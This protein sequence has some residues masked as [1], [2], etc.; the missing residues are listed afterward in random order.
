MLRNGLAAQVF[1]APA[2]QHFSGG[3]R[4]TFETEC[5][6]DGFASDGVRMSEYTSFRDSGMGLEQP[7]DLGGLHLEP[8]A[9]DLVVDSSCEPNTAA[10][11]EVA[12]IS[13]VVPAIFYD[14]CRQ[15]RPVEVARHQ[16]G[17]FHDDLSF[18]GVSHRSGVIQ[19]GNCAAP[20][21]SDKPIGN[22]I[23]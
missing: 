23:S 1:S 8:A 13:G 21:R 22:A 5:S 11:V 15:I 10:L 20:W 17:R 14:G 12:A 19:D 4:A 6:C 9:I 7:I 16:R 3:G 18:A 2:S